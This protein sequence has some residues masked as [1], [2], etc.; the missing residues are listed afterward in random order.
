[1]R[2]ISSFSDYYDGNKCYSHCSDDFTYVR[3]QKKLNLALKNSYFFHQQLTSTREYKCEI[4][5][6]IVGFCGEYYLGYKLLYRKECTPDVV[7]YVYTPEI[8]SKSVQ[9]PI[10]LF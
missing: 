1:M 7:D 5:R 2:L 6:F 9:L 10:V 3:K 8:F 4:Y